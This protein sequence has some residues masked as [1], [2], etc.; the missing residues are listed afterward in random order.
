V[1]VDALRDK[2]SPGALGANEGTSSLLD[3]PIFSQGTNQGTARI[4]AARDGIDAPRPNPCALGKVQMCQCLGF[5]PL[6]LCR[7]D[8]ETQI[9]GHLDLVTAILAKPDMTDFVVAHVRR[10]PWCDQ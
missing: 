6:A 9:D 10:P 8:V 4:A 5:K 1:P 2:E 7:R 3:A